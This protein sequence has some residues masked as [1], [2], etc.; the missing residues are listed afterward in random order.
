MENLSKIVYLLIYPGILGSMLYDILPLDFDL[1]GQSYTWEIEPFSVL[2]LI[3]LFFYL[4]DYWHLYFVMENNY[5]DTARIKFSY[6]FLDLLVAFLLLLAIKSVNGDIRITFLAMALI[7]VCFAIY[8]IFLHFNNDAINNDAFKK[9]KTLRLIFYMSYAV[10]SFLTFIY[11]KC[12]IN[13]TVKSSL[14]IDSVLPFVGLSFL[15]YSAFAI[16]QLKFAKK[17]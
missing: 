9:G 4:L 6:V 10:I 17:T 7:P 11:F 16:S 8:Y 15:A 2:K 3:I 13:L 14:T 1:I 5:K 12:P